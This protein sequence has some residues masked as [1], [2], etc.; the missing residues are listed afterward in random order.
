MQS[1]MSSVVTGLLIVV[2]LAV[3]RQSAAVGSDY[4]N[5]SKIADQGYG[6]SK[7]TTV[8]GGFGES[9]TTVENGK[10]ESSTIAD[11]EGKVE[12]STFADIGKGESSTIAD[13]GKGELKST[14]VGFSGSSTIVSMAR[15][16]DKQQE[17]L[18]DVLVRSYDAK[19]SL[20]EIDAAVLKWSRVLSPMQQEKLK[21]NQK[22]FCGIIFKMELPADD[23]KALVNIMEKGHKEHLPHAEIDNKMKKYADDHLKP[24]QQKLFDSY[25]KAFDNLLHGY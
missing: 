1:K 24:Q 22:K 25:V 20:S 4:D 9:S 2:L 6:D 8:I 17:E 21:V 23:Q 5:S 16:N 10:G 15:L 12:S 11:K 3:I 19:M 18:M 7:S 13:K 14:T